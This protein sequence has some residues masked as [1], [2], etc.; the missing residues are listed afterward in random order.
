MVDMELASLSHRMPPV[1]E[2]ASVDEEWDSRSTHTGASTRS[3]GARLQLPRQQSMRAQASVRTMFP[4]YKAP[5]GNF[6]IQGFESQ[7]LHV[8]MARG[9]R[10]MVEKGGMRYI[11]KGIAPSARMGDFFAY[12]CGGE[13]LFRVVYTNESGE[14]GALMGIAPPFNANIVPVDLGIYEDLVIRGGTFL[15]ATDLDIRIET[16]RVKN[17]SGAMGGHGL[18]VHPLKG[19]GVVFLNAGGTIMT[20]TLREDEELYAS[21]GSIVAFQ[22]SV[23]FSVQFVGGGMANVCCGGQG[24]LNT[25]LVGPGLVILQSLSLAELRLAIQNR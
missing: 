23:D 1:Q 15:A 14:D 22:D 4:D 12:C 2:E 9:D 25:K 5:E 6:T 7:I 11:S 17:L 10:I 3:G 13:E 21:T 20:K 8:T 18:L 24:L 19:T 16:R